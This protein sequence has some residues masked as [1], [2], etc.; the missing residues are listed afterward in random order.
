MSSRF[1]LV[2]LAMAGVTLSIGACAKTHVP[3]TENG[4]VSRAPSVPGEKEIYAVHEAPMPMGVHGERVELL[5]VPARQRNGAYIKAGSRPYVVITQKS[6]PIRLLQRPWSVYFDFDD[7]KVD[8]S[9]EGAI[10]DA[11]AFLNNH[12]DARVL[13]LGYTDAEGSQDYNLALARKRALNVKLKLIEAG[14][15]NSRQIAGIEAHPQAHYLINNSPVNHRLAARNRRVEIMLVGTGDSVSVA[16][17]GG[18]AALVRC[19]SNMQ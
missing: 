13:I 11:V 16:K 12:P 15:R 8:S 7:A 6:R 14:L 19:C 10:Q 3:E 17:G 5:D 9:Q 1:G 2:L 18:K 4:H